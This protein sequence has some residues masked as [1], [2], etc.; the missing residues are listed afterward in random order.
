MRCLTFSLLN[1]QNEKVEALRIP[2]NQ[3]TAPNESCFDQIVGILKSTSASTPI[4]FNCQAGISR[5]TTGMVIAAV[6]KE[7]QG[8]YPT[9]TAEIVPRRNP[10]NDWRYLENTFLRCTYQRWVDLKMGE[11]YQN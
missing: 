10:T 3:D 9:L 8:H 4:V 7:F 11:Y 1:S 5:T 6:V 2:L